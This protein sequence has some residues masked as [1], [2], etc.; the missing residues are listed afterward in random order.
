MSTIKTKEVNDQIRLYLIQNP[1]FLTA[2]YQETANKFNVSYETVRHICRRVRKQI[3]ANEIQVSPIISQDLPKKEFSITDEIMVR[4]E[5]AMVKSLKN[6]LER[7][8]SDYEQ[9]SDAYDLALGLKTQD[10]SKIVMPVID[11]DDRISSEATAII[12]VSDGHFGKVVVPSTVNGL[13]KYNP[14]IARKRME[15]LAQNTLK[16][17]KKERHDVKIENLV[18]ILGGDFLE[19][20]QL[21]MHSEMTT[22]MSPMEETLFSRE[23]LSKF[24]KTVSEYGDFK[25]II[26]PCTR[27]NHSRITKKMVASV[28]YRMNYE[29]ILYRIL[30]QD[31]SDKMFQWHIPDSEI[32]EF[33]VYGTPMRSI[34]GH[35]VKYSGGMGGL[36]VPLNKYIMRLD[37]IRKAS[38]TF[39]H[40]YHSLSYPTSKSTLNGCFVAGSPVTLK[41]GHIKPIEEIVPGDEVLTRSGEFNK[42]LHVIPQESKHENIIAFCSNSNTRRTVR[43]TP[44]HEIWAIKG[45]KIAYKTN[46]LGDNM[47]GKDTTL[48][49][50]KGEWVP[51][52]YLSVGDYVRISTYNL[53]KEDWDKDWCRLLG[54][55]LAEG[56]AAGEKGLN[57]HVTFSFHIN[58][59]EYS[60]FIVKTINRL[61]PDLKVKVTERPDKTIRE[62]V[63]NNTEFSN[64]MVDLCGKGC[65]NK[66]IRED[67]F[68]K[69]NKESLEAILVGWLQGDGHALKKYKSKSDIS[70]YIVGST[71]SNLLASQIYLLSYSIGLTP[72]WNISVPTQ[73]KGKRRTSYN[74]IYRGGSARYLVE[75]TGDVVDWAPPSHKEDSNISSTIF[76]EDGVY[77]R[78]GGVWREK[79]PEIVYDLHVE[80]DHSYTVNG[81]TVHNSIVGYDPYALQIAAEYQPPMQS[82][83]LFDKKRG[84]TIKAPIFCE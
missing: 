66:R 32:S 80:N 45:N 51:A 52:E 20:S 81:F 27:G 36:T 33:E 60:D 56:S 23:L 70:T 77:V 44:N 55:Y 28:D 59:V 79:S 24:I 42:V 26:L 84:F 15:T 49:I 34:H 9:L 30:E 7:A 75:K 25:K 47:R 21:H 12:Q 57:R 83:Q 61:Y 72:Q 67:L 69:L 68:E 5:N 3:D 6:Q 35:T 16:L 65:Y 78:L 31:F 18:L 10:T 63:I 43:C 1:E 53:G 76:A 40:H 41:G 82:F 71:T 73:G 17:I 8:I 46:K 19:N 64:M 13:N 74:I 54:L 29:T 39:M 14:D 50:L 22:A 37:A 48:N 58:E 4:R 2:S 11:G 38:Y 62:V